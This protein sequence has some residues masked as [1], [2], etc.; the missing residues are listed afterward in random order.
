[1]Q[2]MHRPSGT[3]VTLFFKDNTLQ[4]VCSVLSA[5]IGRPVIH[6]SVSPVRVTR[7]YMGMRVR[8]VLDDLCAH[9]PVAFSDDDKALV[10]Q[11]L[12]PVS[13]D[14]R[15][16]AAVALLPATK[17]RAEV[18]TARMPRR[19]DLGDPL[20]AAELAKERWQLLA[21]RAGGTT[22]DAATLDPRSAAAAALAK[23]RWEL[24]NDRASESA[25]KLPD[26]TKKKRPEQF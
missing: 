8:D 15:P 14:L 18:A 26:E 9:Y 7:T 16:K 2:A 25:I 12:V 1:M 3:K 24:L 22:P 17:P 11:D 4:E 19:K 10:M 20:M 21:E 13:M 23:E 6:R 5:S